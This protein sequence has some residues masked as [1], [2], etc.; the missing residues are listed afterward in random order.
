MPDRRDALCAAA[1]IVLAVESAAKATGSPDTVATTG[2][3]RVH[4]GAIN[5]VPSRV[6]WRST[7]A[8]YACEPRDQVVEAIRS[9]RGRR[10]TAPRASRSTSKCSTPTRRRRW[11]DRSS[12]RPRRRV[13]RSGCRF[14]RM[15]SRAYHDSLY[16][17]RICDTG[18]DLHPLPRRRQP[19]AGRVCGAGAIANGVQVLAL[20][21]AAVSYIT[22]RLSVYELTDRDARVRSSFLTI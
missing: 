19:S 15:V 11:P 17:A 12:P 13:K 10:R 3:C 5:S 8:T 4:P 6:T 7:S 14:K 16:M 22:A 18:H 2:V 21:M 9:R 20:T 1:E